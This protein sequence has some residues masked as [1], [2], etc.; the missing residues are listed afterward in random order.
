MNIVMP[1]LE[2]FASELTP[3]EMS[4]V[5]RIH[6][7]QSDGMT[8]EECWLKCFTGRLKTLPNWSTWDGSFDL[9]LND[10][11]ASGAMELRFLTLSLWMA[12]NQTSFE[13]T[14]TILSSPMAAA[15]A[16]LASTYSTCC[17]VAPPVHPDLHLVCRA[18]MHALFFALAACFGLVVMFANTKNAYQQS[19]PP[20]LLS[21]TSRLTMPTGRGT[22]SVLERYRLPQDSCHSH[23]SSLSRSS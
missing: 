15:N 12:R 11:R 23:W 1:C 3:A 13:Y 2:D 17:S 6:Q 22:R 14:G 5:L 19:P 21:A 7:L 8:R 18:A 4:E 16:V 20:T 10:G 9:Y